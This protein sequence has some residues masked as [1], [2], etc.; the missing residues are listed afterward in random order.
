MGMLLEK[1]DRPVKSTR[2]EKGGFLEER[3][4]RSVEHRRFGDADY[5]PH[6]PL[7]GRHS[8][9]GRLGNGSA[10]HQGPYGRADV[11]GFVRAATGVAHSF[12]EADLHCAFG[13]KVLGQQSR[14]DAVGF[15]LLS[16]GARR[17]PLTRQIRAL[18]SGSYDRFL[19][20]RI[21]DFLA[22]ATRDLVTGFGFSVVRASVVHRRRIMRRPN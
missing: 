4:A 22:G 12:P 18:V 14:D 11:F 9:A 19:A 16:Y 10:G 2:T 13:R 3:C 6:S 20:Q 5:F 17:L 7:R 1:R 21:F 15:D 8:H